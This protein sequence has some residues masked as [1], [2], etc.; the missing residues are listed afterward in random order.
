M[1]ARSRPAALAR[2]RA[3]SIATYFSCERS[4]LPS[5]RG[6]V[7]V[8]AGRCGERTGVRLGAVASAR[9]GRL[10]PGGRRLLRHADRRIERRR[11]PARRRGGRRGRGGGDLGLRLL[12]HRQQLLP[13]CQHWVLAVHRVGVL[14]VAPPVH[15]QP[16]LSKPPP[17]RPGSLRSRERGRVSGWVR[18][19]GHAGRRHGLPGARDVH[20]ELPRMPARAAAGAAR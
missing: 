6:G 17:L 19:H 8:G 15:L 4:G 1:L 11:R 14:H 3:A 12:Q 9:V 5:D 2:C 20:L 16:G 13:A 10:C 7:L 18:N